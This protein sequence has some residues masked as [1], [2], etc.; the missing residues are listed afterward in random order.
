M[1]RLGP[2]ETQMSLGGC[3]H[4]RPDSAEALAFCL[5]V[6]QFDPVIA[7]RQLAQDGPNIA[8]RV[9]RGYTSENSGA[10][11]WAVAALSLR[12]GMCRLAA[13]GEPCPPSWRTDVL[14]GPIACV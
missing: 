9:E 7:V 8:Q 2:P 6:E 10:S 4:C 14:S 11:V 13:T 12:S 1:I 5:K 3:Q